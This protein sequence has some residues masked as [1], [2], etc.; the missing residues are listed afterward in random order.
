MYRRAADWLLRYRG[1]PH[2]VALGF[3]VGLFVALTPTVGIQMALGA[4]IAHLLKANRALPVALA[5][6]SNPLT[7]GPLY[8]FNYRIGLLFLPGDEGAG[9]VFIDS[10]SG[11]SLTDPE[12]WWAAIK[13]M[14]AELWGVAG[15]LWLG[16]LII[17]TL[18]AV[19][20]Y[21]IVRRIVVAGRAKLA[22]IKGMPSVP[23]PRGAKRRKKKRAERAET[24]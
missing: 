9:R 19:I 1:T 23:P 13:L 22:D 8:Y 20:A 4:F 6:I 3:A 16:S 2:Q 21:P 10:I 5:W 12:S 15:V 17:A 11:A 14:G 24:S 7:M 18:A